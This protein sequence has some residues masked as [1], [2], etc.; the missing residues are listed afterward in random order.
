M[1]TSAQAVHVLDDQCLSL[2]FLCLHL[3]EHAANLLVVRLLQSVAYALL[4]D[5]GRNGVLV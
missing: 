3:V 5:G 1:L 4:V 2:A